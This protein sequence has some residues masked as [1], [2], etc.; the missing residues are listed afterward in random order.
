[1]AASATDCRPEGQLTAIESSKRAI[2]SQSAFNLQ[3]TVNSLIVVYFYG[4]RE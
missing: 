4:R 3:E 2:K 1:M